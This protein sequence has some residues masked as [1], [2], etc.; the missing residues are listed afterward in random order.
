MFPVQINSIR[1]M[2]VIHN[3]QFMPLAKKMPES[4]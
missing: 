2:G 1:H 3:A 4:E